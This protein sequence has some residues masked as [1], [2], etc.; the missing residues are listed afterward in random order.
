[1]I[2]YNI[3]DS[4]KNLIRRMHNNQK[5]YDI[6]I[7]E[8]VGLMGNVNESIV[9]TDWLSPDDKYLILFDELYDLS[10]GK[11]LGDIWENFDN[12][13]L[14]LSHSFEV[15][16]N[17]PKQ[18]KESAL[19]SIRS[20]ILTESVNDLSK[21]KPVIKLF[22]K[23]EESFFDWIGKG[24]QNTGTF[25]ADSGKKFG[26]DIGDAA[27]KA[28]D[29]LKK[30]GIAISKGDFQEIF[31]LLKKGLVFFAR[32][33]R[34]LLYNPVGMVLD[35]M[36]VATG[37]GKA[38]QWIPWAIVVALDLYELTT[39]DFEHKDEPWWQRGLS[40]G[41][42]V[43]GLVFSGGLAGAART[44]FSVLR[45]A[46]SA[47]ELTVLAAKNPNTINFIG[48]MAKGFS[49][50]PELLQKAATYLKSTKLAKAYPWIEGILGKA[51][52]AMAKTAESL[53]TLAKSASEAANVGKGVVSNTA[54]KSL[55][56]R[57][58]SGL[59]NLGSKKALSAGAKTAGIVGAIDAG[60]KTGAQ[61]YNKL[62]GNYTN[63][64]NGMASSI[65]N[66]LANFK[67]ETGM[68]ISDYYDS[69]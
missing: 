15:A 19:K 38:F 34:S 61:V 16:T 4:E 43:L 68:S 18:I 36:L 33:L 52:G 62:T 10:A 41:V 54:K 56:N 50:V 29:G 8:S 25:F 44:T 58:G 3:S 28:W 30:A 63:D 14:F 45:G 13:K 49:K 31:N 7:K 26:S 65:S 57:V 39:G 69:I 46:R 40:I 42:D 20:L 1:M 17:I 21:M 47:E 12:L 23:E 59:K 48:K 27:S 67:K 2:L 35:A 51:Q 24:V 64:T 53:S 11:K 6:L 9:I 66:S 32:K 5:S 37:I 55:V 60:I 22:L